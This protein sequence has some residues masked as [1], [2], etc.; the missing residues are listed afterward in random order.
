VK[1]N[2]D[3]ERVIFDVLDAAD[4][5]PLDRSK[6]VWLSLYGTGG[7]STRVERL[8][9]ERFPDRRNRPSARA[10]DNALKRLVAAG[11]V[12][13]KLGSDYH[14]DLYYRKAAQR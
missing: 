10:V 13:Q 11:L 9:K 7:L 14:D 5:S 4:E 12:E 2:S 6:K 1:L 8:W 3:T